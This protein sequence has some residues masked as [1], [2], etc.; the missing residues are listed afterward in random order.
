MEPKVVH[1]EANKRYEIFL[2]EDRVGLM[3][4]SLMPGEI[5]LVHTEVDPAHQG[6]NLAAILLRE[7]LADIREKDKEKVVPVCS[8]TVRYMEK[9]PDTHD[10]LLNPIEEAIAQCRWYKKD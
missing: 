10:L 3:D 9:H 5:H 2:E 8:Y 4:Y 1:D 6:K 7:S